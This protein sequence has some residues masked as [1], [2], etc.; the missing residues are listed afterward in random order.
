MAGLIA[1]IGGSKVCVDFADAEGSAV[2]NGRLWKWEFC[3]WGGPLF[4]RKDGRA[5][6]HQNPSKVVWMAF[7]RWLKAYRKGDK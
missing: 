2:V 5:R 7:D 3:Q 4:L 1:T 6:K